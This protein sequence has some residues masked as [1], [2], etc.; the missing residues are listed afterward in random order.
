M[1]CQNCQKLHK[2]IVKLNTQVAYQEMRINDL[3]TRIVEQNKKYKESQ[4]QAKRNTDIKMQ[5]EI[6]K[7]KEQIKEEKE[8]CNNYK[9]QLASVCDDSFERDTKELLDNSQEIETNF[10]IAQSNNFFTDNAISNIR[11]I[12]PQKFADLDSRLL[13]VQSV[14]GSMYMAL[15]DFI[16]NHKKKSLKGDKLLQLKSM[17]SEMTGNITLLAKTSDNLIVDNKALLE[18]ARKIRNNYKTLV[19]R[20]NGANWY[21][22]G[23]QNQK[24]RNT[25][26]NNLDTDIDFDKM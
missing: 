11:R 24:A 14:C 19:K 21:Y 7:L 8:R 9:K 18:C 5:E 15:D 13:T 4:D 2:Q 23:K 16:Q 26:L 22:S 12:D 20:V 25:L 6:A 10:N 3:I 17:L 1:V